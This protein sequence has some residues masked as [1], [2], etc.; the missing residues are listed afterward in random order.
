M[1]QRSRFL[2][3]S[4]LL[5]AALLALVVVG[6]QL[7]WLT[8]PALTKAPQVVEFELQSENPAS[9]PAQHKRKIAEPKK[10]KTLTDLLPSYDISRTREPFLGPK[11]NI[12]LDPRLESQSLRRQSPE[13]DATYD[14]HGT[15]GVYGYQ[16]SMDLQKTIETA[17]FFAALWSKIDSAMEFPKAIAEMRIGGE[18]VVHINVD[19]EGKMAGDFLRIKS[20]HPVLTTHS[21]ILLNQA[22]KSPLPPRSQLPQDHEDVPVVF[23]F[24]YKVVTLTGL[25]PRQGGY[26]RNSLEFSRTQYMDPYL[27]EAINYVF[28]NYVPPIIVY[29]G[30]VYVDFVRA[31]YMID[32]YVNDRPDMYE[33]REQNFNMLRDRLDLAV[34]RDEAE[35]ARLKAKAKLEAPKNPA[36]QQEP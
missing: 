36:Q 21:L 26:F 25:S 1:S 23:R 10:P 19:R 27:N 13:G 18:V 30:G 32:N 9:T 24:K 8:T 15:T 3:L 29:P 14:A 20:D 5:H 7:N 17:P 16:D 35:K 33:Q 2:L 6:D 31:Y 28:A 12:D 22:L 11:P 4:V 34:I